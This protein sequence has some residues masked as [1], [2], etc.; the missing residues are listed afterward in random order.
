MC[1]VLVNEWSENID[2][3]LHEKSIRVSISK[4]D[5]EIER[6]I[7]LERGAEIEVTRA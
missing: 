5:N 2:N 1:E 3:C 4:N 7:T 6:I